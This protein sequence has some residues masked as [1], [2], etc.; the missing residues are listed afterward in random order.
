MDLY[1]LVGKSGYAASRKLMESEPMTQLRQQP[2]QPIGSAEMPYT[3]DF[4]KGPT[5]VRVCM[6]GFWS[7][8]M[9]NA[10]VRD[11]EAAA[12]HYRTR[13]GALKFLIDGRLMA[14]PIA[15]VKE[16][17]VQQVPYRDGDRIALIVEGMLPKIT[18]NRHTQDYSDKFAHQVFT[19]IEDA[20]AW[21]GV[22]G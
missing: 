15:E 11:F 13:F 17:L 9:A 21:L 12:R 14:L 18:A 6:R 20:E 8:E 7:I 10:Y 1:S 22:G 3:I 4:E 2:P 5:L 16:I 19:S